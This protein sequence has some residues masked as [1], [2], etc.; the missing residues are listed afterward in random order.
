VSFG[1]RVEIRLDALRSNFDRLRSCLPGS[2]VLAAVKANAY[3]HGLT[4]ISRAL[5]DAD[6]LAVARLGEAETLREAGVA[7]D[8][9]LMGGVISRDELDRAGELA[10]DLVVHSAHQVELLES[11]RISPRRVWLKVDSGMRRLG[12]LPEACG[13]LIPRLRRCRS[14]GPLGIMTHLANADDTGD[15]ASREQFRRFASA[16]DGFD[17][18]IS[19]A[20]SAAL[21]G[22]GDDIQP[23]RHWSVTGET[24][25]RPGISLYGVSP[26]R[27]VSAADLG[28]QPVMNFDTVLIAVKRV[29]AGEPVGYGGTWASGRDTTLGIAAAGYGDGYSRS[30]P[31]GTPVLVNGRRAA[32]A[33]VVSMDLL[34]ID[35]GP[36]AAE[37]IGDPV[38]LWGEGLPVEEVA[39][40]AGTIA[41]ALVTGVRDRDGRVV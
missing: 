33:G 31:S 8:I 4:G 18:D 36:E 3:G 35:L 40:Y 32:L 1:A 24:W 14:V 5:P 9:V 22:W 27:G 23:G 2:R 21:L 26:L 19:I 20:N 13:E 39:A 37:Y 34:A 12:V 10:C 6:A 16:V 30:L 7:N 29:S 17:G 15:P 25:I 11:S 38:R 41:Y 28:L